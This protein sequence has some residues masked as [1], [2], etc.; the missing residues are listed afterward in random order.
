MGTG[1]G[2]NDLVCVGVD[3][4]VGIVRDHDHLALRLSLDEKSDKFVIDR[5]RIQVFFRLI[6][7]ERALV[8]IVE[9][10][11]QKEKYDAPCAGDSLRIS[12]PS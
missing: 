8:S 2:N 10:E 11:V 3:H 12:T 9:R 5:F 4:E 1:R 6:D 7:D